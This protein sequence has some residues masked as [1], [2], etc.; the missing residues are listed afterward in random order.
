CPPGAAG[1]GQMDLGMRV[2][3]FAKSATRLRLEGADVSFAPVRLLEGPL[4]GFLCRLRADVIVS[5]GVPAAQWSAFAASRGA[6]LSAIGGP[7]TLAGI[8]PASIVC[9]GAPRRRETTLQ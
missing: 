7:S 1:R 3:A 6:S 2:F 5:L 8:A 4:D 9:A